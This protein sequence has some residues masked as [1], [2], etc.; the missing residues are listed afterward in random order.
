MLFVFFPLSSIFSAMKPA[1]IPA[2]AAVEPRATQ[3]AV[4]MAPVAI[5]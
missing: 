4:E 1:A 2:A 5:I 3:D